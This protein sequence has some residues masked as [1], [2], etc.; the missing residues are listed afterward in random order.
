MRGIAWIIPVV[1]IMLLLSVT[2]AFFLFGK[3]VIIEKRAYQEKILSTGNRLEITGNMIIQAADLATIQALYDI[4]KSNVAIKN[5]VK[6]NE[7][8][9][10]PYFSDEYKD[11]II[12]AS[13]KLAEKYFENYN[14]SFTEYFMNPDSSKDRYNYWFVNWEK[15][16][17]LKSFDE[18][19]ISF[20]FGYY[21]ITYDDEQI[22]ISKKYPLISYVKTKIFKLIDEAE[23]V[24]EM[25]EKGEQ[26]EDIQNSLS[27][28]DIKV[29]LDDKGDYIVVSIKEN[30]VRNFYIISEEKQNYD[31][32]SLRF[33]ID[34]K[35]CFC[36]YSTCDNVCWWGLNGPYECNPSFCGANDIGVDLDNL[37]GIKKCGE[38]YILSNNNHKC[39]IFGI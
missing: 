33:V 3:K 10:L 5:N 36:I 37:S 29:E 23:R 19:G 32:F 30:S 17:K 38:I 28:N 35:K 25:I 11:Y 4:S 34:K 13:L 18:K 26:I 20:N 9:K 2:F 22:R 39:N 8:E 12:Q 21:N 7:I 27:D 6:Y 16:I 31:S 24:Y 14:K 15:E 1:L